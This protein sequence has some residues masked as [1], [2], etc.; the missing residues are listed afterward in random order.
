M[1]D[2]YDNLTARLRAGGNYL[3]PLVLR[4]IMFWEFWEAGTA[5]LNGDNWFANIPWADWQKGFPWPFSD[6][7][8]DLNWMAATE[9]DGGHLGRTVL[10]SND[11]A[12]PIDAVFRDLA[13]RHHGCCNRRGTLAS[14]LGFVLPTVARLR[15]HQRGSR[16]LQASPALYCDPAATGVPWRWKNKPGPSAVETDRP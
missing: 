8:Q 5:K 7:S 11:P 3:W 13:Y 16:Q 6:L 14:G 9:L 15:H 10:F 1:F 4:L 12:G 2:L